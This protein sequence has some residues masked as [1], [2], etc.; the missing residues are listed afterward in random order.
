MLTA[1]GFLGKKVWFVLSKSTVEPNMKEGWDLIGTR[2]IP[3]SN[4]HLLCF[5]HCLMR[6]K[7]DSDQSCNKC[8]S[9]CLGWSGS[10]FSF[11]FSIVA[12]FVLFVCMRAHVSI[13]I[14]RSYR[15]RGL[16]LMNSVYTPTDQCSPCRITDTSGTSPLPL[17]SRFSPG[18]KYSSCLMWNLICTERRGACDRFVSNLCLSFRSLPGP[19]GDVGSDVVFCQR[20]VLQTAFRSD[21]T[22]SRSVCPRSGVIVQIQSFF[23]SFNLSCCF[24]LFEES[25]LLLGMSVRTDEC[26]SNITFGWTFLCSCVK[27]HCSLN[28]EQFASFAKFCSLESCR[29]ESSSVMTQYFHASIR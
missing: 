2:R 27:F 28:T 10:E 12:V 6:G 19:V 22:L 8:I 26:V 24:G 13:L 17:S 23:P 16:E 11:S 7:Y 18:A 21:W 9:M 15:L 5:H 29:L 3:D 20:L 25:A 1:H 4:L 14:S